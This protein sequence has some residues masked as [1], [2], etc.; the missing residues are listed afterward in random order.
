MNA[1]ILYYSKTGFTKRYA[2]WI[3]E[4]LSCECV[5]FEQRGRVDFP[6]M[7]RLYSAAVCRRARCRNSAGSKTAPCVGG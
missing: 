5:S 1:I 4:A 6:N 7:I 3:S 2:Q